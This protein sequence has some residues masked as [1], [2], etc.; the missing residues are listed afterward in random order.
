M[1]NLLGKLRLKNKDE[2][3][4]EEYFSKIDYHVINEDALNTKT[5]VTVIVPVYNAEKYLSQTIDSVVV[6]HIGFQNVTLILVD[7]A[8]TDRSKQIMREYAQLYPNIVAIFLEENTGTPA[9]PR[10]LGIYLANSSYVLFLDADDWLSRQGLKTLYDLM[11]KTGVN[12]AAGKTM[13]VESKRQKIVAPYTSCADREG[14]SPFSIRH[15]FYHLGPPSRMVKLDLLRQHK[16]F[17]PEM[18][19]AEDKQ[20][21]IDVLSVAGKIS[22][23]TKT[24]YYV[25]RRE[26][27][28]SLTTKTNVLEKMDTNLTVLRH[29]LDKNLPVEQEKMI[30]NRL[31]EFD[32]I[33]RLFDRKHFIK[34]KNKSAYYSKLKKAIKIFKG[35]RRSYELE[36]ILIKPLAQAYF[37]LFMQKEYDQL[38]E[39]AKWSKSNE[40]ATFMMKDGTLYCKTSLENTAFS[41]LKVLL[42]VETKDVSMH[43]GNI[44][45]FLDPEKSVAKGLE[46]IQFAS[47]A[48]PDTVYLDGECVSDSKGLQMIL[49]KEK[50]ELLPEG[51][52]VMYAIYNGY[53]KTMLKKVDEKKVEWIANGKKYQFYQ[54]INGNLSLKI[55]A[56]K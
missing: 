38:V 10:N 47:R 4:E 17:F 43:G 56:E 25:N 33:A 3:T 45:I 42:H 8:S 6:Q 15:M 41:W 24:I 21:F 48:A 35:Y 34:S 50:I 16:I 9:F 23:T 13:K 36:D 18:K 31:I 20:F 39:L 40:E 14:V 54:T 7:D 12:Y 49:K 1:R 55:I 2:S 46:T 30:V 29:V 22:T 44:H 19:F 26:D 32:C 53:E 11:E 27:N 37:R 52:Y 51:G 28:V 5:A